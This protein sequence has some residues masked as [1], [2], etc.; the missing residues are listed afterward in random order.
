[1]Q[2]FEVF[3]SLGFGLKV[4]MLSVRLRVMRVCWRF[5][6]LWWLLLVGI[7]AVMV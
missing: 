1:M 6:R 7:Y 2:W 3:V 5:E 4:W